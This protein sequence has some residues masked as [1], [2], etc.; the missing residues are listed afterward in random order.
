M[1][2]LQAA[3]ISQS[4]SDKQVL[5][6][7]DLR[8]DEGRIY[9]IIGPNGSGKSTLLHA[10]SRQL[11]PDAGDVYWKEHNLY[12]L[13]PKKVAQEL[14]LLAQ[15]NDLMDLTVEQLIAYG[16]T[17]HKSMFQ[18][19]DEDDQEIIDEA[20]HLTKLDSLRKRNVS[21]LSGGE[22]QRAWIALCLAQQPKVFFLDEPTTYLDISHQLDVLEIV[23]RL[24]ETRDVTVVM[25]LHDLNHAAT[26][27]DEVIVVREGH[28]Y[29]QG[30]PKEVMNQEMFKEVFHVQSDIYEDEHDDLLRI[31]MKPLKK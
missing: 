12:Q 11:K 9:S 4:F 31:V 14:A 28:I 13:A 5:N 1:T 23:S 15:V 22:R 3:S 16:R 24:K 18:R 7:I 6:K 26:Y 21:H 30:I 20:I 25:V 2:V 17:P 10:L 19:L 27:S 29:G 8:L